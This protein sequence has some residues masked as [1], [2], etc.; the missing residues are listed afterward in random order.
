MKLIDRV[1]EEIGDSEDYFYTDKGVLVYLEESLN[2]NKHLVNKVYY[3]DSDYHSEYGHSHIDYGETE[4]YH[5]RLFSHESF[6]R[7]LVNHEDADRIKNQKKKLEDEITLLNNEINQLKIFK[8][9]NS[10]DFE[11]NKTFHIAHQLMTNTKRFILI[12][13][14]SY[15]FSIVDNL[16]KR[17]FGHDPDEDQYWS[18]ERRYKDIEF[19]IYR[20][21]S[22]YGNPKDKLF[23]FSI[24]L[25]KDND[26]DWREDATY[27][28]NKNF[29]VDVHFFDTFEEI[30]S[31]ADQWARDDKLTPSAY[32]R[33]INQCNL[34]INPELGEVFK[35]Q[36]VKNAKDVILDKTKYRD[37]Y[38]N[39]ISKANKDLTD[40]ENIDP[41]DIKTLIGRVRGI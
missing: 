41:S 28:Y 35:A 20:D 37:N 4:I 32:L 3:T 18:S 24:R 19:T 31:I 14:S 7:T 27:I 10:K 2:E 17:L 40:I 5:G 11:N 9:T 16:D 33:L 30:Q 22:L 23:N 21:F 26:N 36:L 12:R 38:V 15:K 34:E 25:K 6:S 39:D 1:I 13:E 29:D 8:N